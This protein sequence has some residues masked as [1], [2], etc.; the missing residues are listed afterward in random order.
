MHCNPLPFAAI[1]VSVTRI[2]SALHIWALIM[3]IFVAGCYRQSI[4]SLVYSLMSFFIIFKRPTFTKNMY[5]ITTSTV[6]L[7]IS[8]VTLIFTIFCSIFRM[9]VF[10]WFLCS[11]LLGLLVHRI[12]RG[13]EPGGLLL[14]RLYR[15]SSLDCVRDHYFCGKQ[16]TK[17]TRSLSISHL[18]ERI[19]SF[20]TIDRNSTDSFPCYHH[21][22]VV[23][24]F[25]HLSS[26]D[27]AV[28]IRPP[29]LSDHFHS[30]QA[31]IREEDHQQQADLHLICSSFSLLLFDVLIGF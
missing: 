1:L 12:L 8:T 5:F 4:V 25:R 13:Q 15:Y 30:L 6:T 27:F 24:L 10:T 23:C 18:I 28:C 17:C 22:S 19:F 14:Q 11:L 26:L 21:H 29:S 7:I 2:L 3:V 9:P 20:H 31:R 16:K